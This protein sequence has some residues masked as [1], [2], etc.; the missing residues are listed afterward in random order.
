MKTVRTLPKVMIT[1]VFIIC[2]AMLL[3]SFWDSLSPDR[4]TKFQRFC[5]EKELNPDLT[6]KAFDYMPHYFIFGIRLE[7]DN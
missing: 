4:K 5:L 1:I 6:N 3:G 7:S 2:F